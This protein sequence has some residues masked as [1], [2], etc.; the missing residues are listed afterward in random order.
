MK[1]YQSYKRQE[2][3]FVRIDEPIRMDVN[4]V[5]IGVQYQRKAISILISGMD[6]AW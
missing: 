3:L 1:L 6:W 2:K 5:K 4:R